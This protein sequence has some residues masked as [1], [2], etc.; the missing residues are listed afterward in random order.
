MG[1]SCFAEGRELLTAERLRLLKLCLTLHLR[2]VSVVFLI[3]LGGALHEFEKMPQRL[4]FCA[5]DRGEA[6][7]DAERRCAL[8][9]DSVQHHSLDPQLPA[10]EPK[11]DFYIF[12]RA[13]GSHR[14]DEASSHA[15]I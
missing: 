7:A 2:Q 13:N 10:C 8:G 1:Y 11:S 9:H 14:L 3:A 4:A 12:A 6:H 5:F 15:G